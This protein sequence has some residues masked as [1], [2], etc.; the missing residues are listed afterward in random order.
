MAPYKKNEHE[1]AC[2]YG[3]RSAAVAELHYWF[4]FS[5]HH[6]YEEL[7]HRLDVALSFL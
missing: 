6:D 2:A 1:F 3:S 7:F 5:P 4:R